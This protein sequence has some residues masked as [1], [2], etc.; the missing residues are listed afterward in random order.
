MCSVSVLVIL[1]FVAGIAYNKF[2]LQKSGLDVVPQYTFWISIPG[3]VKD[4]VMFVVE[5]F[6]RNNYQSV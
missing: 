1:Y 4:G 5:R 3:L 6:K 2:K